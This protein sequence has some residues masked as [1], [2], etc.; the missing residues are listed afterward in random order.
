MRP[1]FGRIRLGAFVVLTTLQAIFIHANVRLTFGPLR[2][3][4]ATPQFHHWHHAPTRQPMAAQY[5][6]DDS[7]PVGY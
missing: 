3:V 7:E 1:G 4:I 6:I 5:G 2:W